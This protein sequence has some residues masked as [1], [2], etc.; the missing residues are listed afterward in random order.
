MPTHEFSIGTVLF[1]ALAFELSHLTVCVTSAGADVDS[2]W[3]QKKL[4]ARKMLEK[5]HRTSASSA[6]SYFI[7]ET[8]AQW[9][10]TANW[11]T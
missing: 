6:P 4:E 2:V 11:Q 8:G 1:Y 9:E 5:P 3:E 10:Y 7:K